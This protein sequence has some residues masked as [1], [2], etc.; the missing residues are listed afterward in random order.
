[1]SKDKEHQQEYLHQHEHQ[2]Q[3]QHDGDEHEHVCPKCGAQ[4]DEGSRFCGECG[5][6]IG[7]QCTFCGASLPA[8][9][10][11]CPEC[12][13][14]RAGI[15]C[16]VCRTV[17]YRSFCRVC[18]HPLNA[19]AQQALADAY[20]DPHYIKA[21]AIAEELEELE[22]QIANL[23][24]QISQT[25]ERDAQITHDLV[26][27]NTVS[28]DTKNLLDEYEKILG[29]KSTW[30]PEVKQPKQ[31]VKKPQ[32]SA[33]GDDWGAQAKRL[34]QLKKA[35]QAK[36]GELQEQL[37][38]MVPDPTA[39]PEMQRNFACA[40]MVTVVSRKLKKEI[41]RVAWVCN[42]CQIWHNNPSDCGVREYGGRW[43]ARET[44]T[45]TYNIT[46]KTVNL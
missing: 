6:E 5:A 20:R 26:I 2:H 9:A 1:M 14:P 7:A 31:E 30:K 23:E 12:G 17:N 39:P 25:K 24:S 4:L 34:E 45:E 36:L 42:R 19:M 33:G 15:V 3:H 41:S 21:Q 40:H 28:T 27:D 16:P 10:T 11:H 35:H 32:T 37:D 43:V 38:A 46:S 13:N 18:N 29:Q 8:G 44:V 22:E